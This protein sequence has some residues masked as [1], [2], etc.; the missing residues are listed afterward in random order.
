MWFQHKTLLVIQHFVQNTRYIHTIMIERDTFWYFV[1][2]IFPVLSIL[3]VIAYYESKRSRY[4]SDVYCFLCHTNLHYIYLLRKQQKRR[5]YVIKSFFWCN[6]M[7]RISFKYLLM[8]EDINGLTCLVVDVGCI[9][10][11]CNSQRKAMFHY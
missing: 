2:A 1:R 5:K 9:Q 10:Q 4:H 6:I 3:F 11:K 8:A 7:S